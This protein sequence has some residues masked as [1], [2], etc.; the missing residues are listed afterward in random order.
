MYQNIDDA[1]E[2]DVKALVSEMETLSG[3][4]PHPN[5]VSLV[6]VCT[7]GSMC[8]I[9]YMSISKSLPLDLDPMY[10]VMEYM[11]HG[12]LLGF[13]RASRG[14][15]GMYH[16]S[17]GTRYQPPTLNLCSRDLLNVATKIANGMRYLSDRKVLL[18]TLLV[19]ML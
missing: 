7:V 4:G 8:L 15:H 13:L 3:L 16:I 11:C 6:R 2:D 14:H 9:L 10:V 12:D 17:P 5:I 19:S 18:H 1:N